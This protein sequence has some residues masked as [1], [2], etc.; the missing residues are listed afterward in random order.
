M[1]AVVG[2]GRAY[3]RDPV[4]SRVEPSEAVGGR[5]GLCRR[6]PTMTLPRSVSDVLAE[7]VTLEVEC[8]DWMYLNV[9][10]P[11]L[12]FPEGAVK[13]IRSHLGNPIASTVMVAAIT[14][15]FVADTCGYVT[16]H[17][18]P[19]I[20]FVKGQRKDDVM[21]EHLAQFE[22][23]EGVLFVGRAQEKANIFRTEKRRNRETGKSY[24]FIVRA[25]AMV[26]HFYFYAV[27]DDFGPFFI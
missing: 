11:R 7:H 8:I 27:D 5:E 18:V 2:S 20:D 22:G 19:L 25:S 1:V 14:E 24:P 3:M 10:V 9:Y 16:D 6:E 23:N 15:R 12:Q 17:D 21:H 13:F 4:G 26:N